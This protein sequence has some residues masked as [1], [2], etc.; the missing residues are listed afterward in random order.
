MARQ[1]SGK[2]ILACP[3]S[4]LAT[5]REPYTSAARTVRDFTNWI[6]TLGPQRPLSAMIRPW[7]L[8]SPAHGPT[9]GAPCLANDVLP[10]G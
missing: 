2:D 3:F 10:S 4:L 1:S 8:S 7:P 6:K 9:L 5:P